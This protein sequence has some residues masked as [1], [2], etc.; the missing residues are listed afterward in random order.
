[1][2]AR[3]AGPLLIAAVADHGEALDEWLDVRDYAFDHGEFLDA[4]QIRIPLVLAGPGVAPGRSTGAVSI[5]DLY[6]TLLAA[7]GVASDAADAPVRDL[8]V[9]SDAER[10]VV[11]ERRAA[12]DAELAADPRAAA[13][14]R[15]HG[16]A[17]MDGRVLA[18]LGAD[19]AVV[20]GAT[21]P[22]ALLDAGRA[23][24]GE[25]SQQRAV[26]APE[27]DAAT[28]DALRSLGYTR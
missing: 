2:R 20:D 10:V 1:V 28:R 11:T 5:G 17:A 15:A 13:A 3:V 25:A 4:D 6:G 7:A 9:A 18:V 16:V 22:A 27:V 12:D 19:G 8:R 23:A 26:A 14:L 24:L 21:A